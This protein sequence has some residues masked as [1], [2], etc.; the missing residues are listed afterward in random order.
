M[1]AGPIKLGNFEAH[2][3]GKAGLFDIPGYLDPA[4]TWDDVRWVRDLWPGKL[5]I[6]GVLTPEDAEAAVRVGADGISVSNHGGNQLD[7][8]LS[9]IAA[10]PAV[11]A[12][13]GGRL[14][15]LLDGGVRSGQDVL[16]ALALGARGCLLG[17][18]HLYGLGAAGQAGVA[19]AIEII[20]GELD[21]TIG[22]CGLTDVRNASRDLLF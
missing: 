18:A 15:V 2:R 13:V 8:A 1:L 17:R 22:L 9:T 11:A 16:K 20:R 21:T 3:P 6:K 14:E 19:K 12:A 5:V 4:A 7:G 10:L